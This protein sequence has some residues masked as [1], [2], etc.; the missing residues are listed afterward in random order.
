MSA[1]AWEL[2]EEVRAVR[3]G[4][5][6]FARK[7]VLPRHYRHRDLF[8]N[9]PAPALSR[10]RTI[11]RRIEGSYRRGAARLRQGRLLQHV[12]P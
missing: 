1:I 9:E 12:C 5:L 11:L 7:E 8:E 2:P 10:G 3:D 6:D 4:L